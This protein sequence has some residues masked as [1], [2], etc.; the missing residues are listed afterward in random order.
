MFAPPFLSD[1]APYLQSVNL[2]K[3]VDTAVGVWVWVGLGWAIRFGGGHSA[4]PVRVI[5]GVAV[6]CMV[7]TDIVGPVLWA[8]FTWFVHVKEGKR[9]RRERMG[10]DGGSDD[11]DISTS[12]SDSSEGESSDEDTS[13]S[14]EEGDEEEGYYGD[15]GYDGYD[16]N[17]NY[18]SAAATYRDQL[19]SQPAAV[20]GS[21]VLD[22]AVICK[23][24]EFSSDWDRMEESGQFNC[25]TEHSPL[26]VDIMAHLTSASFFVIASGVMDEG[27][28]KLY[29]LAQSEGNR[30]LIDM[31]FECETQ[32]LKVAFRTEKPDLVP[33]VVK[34]LRLQKLFGDFC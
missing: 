26:M 12:S 28:F 14:E 30:V 34:C 15:T 20:P 5:L 31:A 13:E 19:G 11:E 9:R 21:F 16:E 27:T 25:T 33:A 4:K 29:V 32:R 24:N 2:A 3:F 7:V 1:T 22:R 23:P 10:G 17:A 6:T 8:V 18:Y